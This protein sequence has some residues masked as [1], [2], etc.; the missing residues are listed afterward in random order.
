MSKIAIA[1]AGMMY[2]PAPWKLDTSLYT[3]GEVYLGLLSNGKHFFFAYR[4]YSSK[5][6]TLFY[7][8]S[9]TD[10][11]GRMPV[12]KVSRGQHQP[13]EF[14]TCSHKIDYHEALRRATLLGLI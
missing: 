12:A 4:G 14:L 1:A 8:C 7:M 9:K 3:T 2:G 5:E 6:P 13:S 11:A 10:T